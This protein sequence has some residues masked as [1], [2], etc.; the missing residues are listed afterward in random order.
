MNDDS[1]TEMN[2]RKAFQNDRDD[3]FTFQLSIAVAV[4]N[5]ICRWILLDGV[6]ECGRHDY[7]AL[8]RHG[9]Q[10]DRHGRRYGCVLNQ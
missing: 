4:E 7:A 8:R 2:G 1:Q 3:T 9:V 5:G 10:N 6:C